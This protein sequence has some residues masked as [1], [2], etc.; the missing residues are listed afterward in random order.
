MKLLSVIATAPYH[1]ENFFPVNL[2]NKKA[3]RYLSEVAYMFT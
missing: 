3:Y 2:L 1:F